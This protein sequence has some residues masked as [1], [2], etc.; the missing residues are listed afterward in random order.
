M[1][2]TITLRMEQQEALVILHRRMTVDHFSTAYS[3][4]LQ[5]VLQTQQLTEST[6]RSH[7]GHSRVLPRYRYGPTMLS[8]SISSVA[9][10]SYQG[11]STQEARIASSSLEPPS[12]YLRKNL[13]A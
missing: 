6:S 4:P 13:T 11:S 10:C 12:D 8:S 3:H 9:G 7:L 5:P 2:P 1:G